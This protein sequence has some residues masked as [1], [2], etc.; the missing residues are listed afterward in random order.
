LPLIVT[1]DAGSVLEQ[2]KIIE[3][4]TDPTAHGG[5][6]PMLSIW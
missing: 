3:P 5:R 1:T 4:L 6:Q 2:L